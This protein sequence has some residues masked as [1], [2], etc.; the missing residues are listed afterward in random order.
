[1]IASTSSVWSSSSV[2]AEKES[3]ARKVKVPITTPIAAATLTRS[4]SGVPSSTAL[5]VHKEKEG[6]A[7]VGSRFKTDRRFGVVK[8]TMTSEVRELEPPRS[9]SIRG[10]DGPVRANV[11]VTVE[12]SDGSAHSRV[13]VN[14]DFEGRGL[15]GKLLV[16]LYVRPQ[17]RKAAPESGKH[18]KERLESGS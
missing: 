7:V 13:T 17:A 10:V 9:W 12:P 2:T 6:P 18:L 11:D 1:L 5:S 15:V 3:A 14:L 16:P 4:P 8:R